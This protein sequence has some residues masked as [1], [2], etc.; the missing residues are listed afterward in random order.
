M[1]KKLLIGLVAVL[2]L[3]AGAG[4]A[5]I[6]LRHQDSM[7]RARAMLAKGDLRSAG[8]ELRN[9]VR[10][11]PTNADA[12]FRL[13][14]LDLAT[15]DPV[16]AGREARL[17]RRNGYKPP[18]A[19]DLVAAQSL[20]QQGKFKDLLAEFK[21]DGLPPPE[22]SF[23]LTLRALAS[24]GLGDLAGAHTLVD[25]AEK[26][27]PT[28]ADAT[29]AAARIAFAQRDYVRAEHDADR[30]LALD[31]KRVDALILK[32]QLENA[33]GSRTGALTALDQAVSL[34]PDNLSARLE[35][36]NVL[37][38]S[39]QDTKAMTDV[40]TVLAHAPRAV[41]AIFLKAVLLTRKH[42][43]HGADGELQ[44][45]STLLPRLP[46]GDYFLAMTKA[47][48][49]Q[50]AQAADAAER[51]A[52]RNP[53]DLDGLKLLAQI[54]LSTNSPDPVIRLLGQAADTGVADAGVLDLLG[55]AYA[56]KG[57]PAQ[58][59]QTLTQASDLAPNNASI[60]THLASSRMQLGD[61]AGAAG[62]LERSLQRQ[63]NQV[64]AEEALVIAAVSAG[65]ISRAQ[66]T[67]D[68]LR[69]QVGETETVGNL[70]G[71]IKLAQFDLAGARSQFEAVIKAFP[72]S[73]PAK[74]NLAHVEQLQ[75][76]L[77]DAERNLS[78]ALKQDPTNE[79]A[80]GAMTG[81]LLQTNRVARAV[82]VLETA[83]KAAPANEAFTAALSDLEVRAGDPKKALAM[84]D[85]ATGGGTPSP[86]LLAARARAQV[87]MSDIAG[88]QQSWRSILAADPKNVTIRR[89]LAASLAQQKDYAAAQTVLHDGLVQDPGNSGLLIATVALEQASKGVPAAIALADTLRKD[90][91]NMPAVALLKGDLLMTNHQFGD[92]ASAYQA[93]YKLAPSSI[94]ANHAAL[95]LAA[96]GAPAAAR[97]QLDDWLKRSPND[98]DTLREL[99]SLDITDRRFPEAAARLKQVLAARPN[100]G[101][102]LNN[103]AWVLQQQGDPGALS[104]ARRAFLLA[105]SASVADTLG[106]I[107][108]SQ[109]KAAEALP[110]LRQAAA[111]QPA[112]PSVQYHLAL[113]LSDTDH[114]DE[115]VRV[116]TEI[117]GRPGTFEDKANAQKLLAKLRS[118]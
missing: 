25:Q 10:D 47:A 111:A 109:G 16:A 77:E 112:D 75:G 104:A 15:G 96:A 86:Q 115:A 6:M 107:L 117:V 59:V 12:H 102:A 38:L 33:K 8:I 2:V 97:T 91:A 88:A 113:A 100:D 53:N 56:M 114:K 76:K 70:T 85:E 95:A 27:A 31:G 57:Q 13:A 108:A 63:P 40:D 32:G 81:L 50:S 103:L 19:A 116:L 21:A 49:G 42:D 5:W 55:R 43:W 105:P 48:L 118:P 68:T 90:P 44:K 110:L 93:E 78:D 35:R 80:L 26:L 45:V 92:A 11:Q 30:T 7:A 41:G 71:L 34:A 52:A 79:A 62:T 60:L 82:A 1:N 106:W 65:D 87:A 51:Y 83:H 9:A 22:A 46:R 24:A 74:L 66:S 3:V 67:L 23:M 18:E 94:L 29:L 20:L 69:G 36:A 61:A 89:F 39:S 28:S 54:D 37:M 64:N 72:Q 58:A 99:A 17:A 14:R 98:P 84:L 101:V 4:G 73:I